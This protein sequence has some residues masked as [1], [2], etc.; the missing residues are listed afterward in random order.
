LVVWV[1]EV[2]PPH[3]DDPPVGVAATVKVA[4]VEPAVAAGVDGFRV[5]QVAGA[6]PPDVTAVNG[7]PSPAVELTYT[8]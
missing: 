3:P 8:V 6:F 4:A 2:K 5:I 7:I 1:P